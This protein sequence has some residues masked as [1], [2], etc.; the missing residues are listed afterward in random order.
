MN[1]ISYALRVLL[2]GIPELPQAEVTR[3]VEVP[4]MGSAEPASVYSVQVKTGKK[5]EHNYGYSS[6]LSD[7]YKTVYYA[8]CEQAH[9]EHPDKAVTAVSVWRIGR[10]HVTDVR[11]TE[12]KV[13]P[14]PK[15]AKGAK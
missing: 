14:K 15:R 1:R 10:S 11:L 6:Y 7:E 4:I 5:V 8:T 2:H 12:I 3:E 9:A 13:E